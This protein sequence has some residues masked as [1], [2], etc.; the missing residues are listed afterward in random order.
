MNANNIKKSSKRLSAPV[1]KN[2]LSRAEAEVLGLFITGRNSSMIAAERGCSRSYVLRVLKKLSELG[3]IQPPV[4]GVGYTYQPVQP[5]N[6]ST[7]IENNV[8]SSI[9]N[10]VKR[11]HAQRFVFKILSSGRRFKKNLAQHL[12]DGSWVQVNGNRLYLMAAKDLCFS[13]A[14]LDDAVRNA[15]DFWVK[16][17]P[18]IESDLDCRFWKPRVA[19]E[20]AYTEVATEGSRIAQDVVSRRGHVKVYS[21]KDNKLRL[22]F[23]MSKGKP[24]HEVHHR[25]SFLE[26]DPSFQHQINGLL[27]AGS[28]GATLADL[29]KAVIRLNR[30]LKS[31]V[32]VINTLV[33]RSIP[34]EFVSPDWEADYFG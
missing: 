17:F 29:N 16:R 23:D 4:P 27:D 31:Q 14:S 21:N 32:E 34:P 28:D 7:I 8:S 10:N 6:H 1:P 3:Y 9:E 13:G 24:E 19:F 11:V 26:D 33:E 30:V 2:I 15:I 22:S 18:Q 5:K 20:I 25:E 12:S